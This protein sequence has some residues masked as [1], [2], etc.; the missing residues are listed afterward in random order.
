[1]NILF[2]CQYYPP[3]GCAP[4]ARVSELARYWVRAGHAVTVLTGFPNHPTGIIHE[5]YRKKIHHLVV[6]ETMDEV[7]VVRTWLAAR[8]NR[9]AWERIVN[10]SSFCVSATISGMLLPRA[11][12]V[13][14]TSPT[15]LVGLAGWAIA[16]ARRLPFIFEVRDLWPESLNGVGYGGEN[17]LLGKALRVLARFLYRRSDHLVTVSSGLRDYLV[18]QCRVTPEKV[19]VVENGVDVDLFAPAS[20]SEG[21]RAVLGLQN[22]FV[23]SYVGTLGPSHGLNTLLEAAARLQHRLPDTRFLVVGEGGDKDLL[24]QSAAERRLANVLF[25]GQ[26]PRERVPQLLGASDICLVPLKKADVFKLVLPSKMFESMACARPVVLS[27]DGVARQLLEESG[28]GLAIEPENAQALAEAVIRLHDHSELRMALGANARA[29]VV[30]HF[31]RDRL[32]Q[33]YA[34]T[35]QSLLTNGHASQPARLTATHSRDEGHA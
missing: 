15:L 31:R 21:T 2:V 28:G 25:L 23:V 8:P 29:Y 1:M 5:A 26:Q 6:R 16:R 24:A 7:R 3:E 13:I 18:Q 12:V 22:R 32:A 27:V 14:A 19:S 34:S 9:K 30:K 33:R 17:S 35:L 4:A 10:Y 20:N 11:D